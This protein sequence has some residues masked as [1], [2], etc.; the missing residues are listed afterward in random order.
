MTDPALTNSPPSLAT[1]D[2]FRL[3]VDSLVDRAVLMLDPFG[4]IVSWNRGAESIFRY[5]SQDIVGSHFSC[6]Y[7]TEA[8]T[9][10][11]PERALQA[12]LQHTRLQGEYLQKRHDGTLF[13]AELSLTELK[14]P[15]GSHVGFALV[16]TDIS[17]RKRV[18][19]SVRRERD[20]N[21]HILNC[22][23]GIF[24]M[25]DESGQFL[26][27]NRR[28]ETISEYST[29]EMEHRR[30]LDFF[31]GDEKRL[32]AERIA[33]V[34]RDGHDEVEAHFV[35]R[36]GTR[37]PYYFNGVRA[38]ID[39]RPC[40][41][42]VGL[43]LS[44]QQ[45][46]RSENR[47][48]MQ[49]L[50]ERVKELTC[51][52]QA[53]RILQDNQLTT[54]EWLG[55]LSLLLPS[56]WQYCDDAA[57]RI[58]YGDLEFRSPRFSL[59]PW[60][61]SETFTDTVGNRCSI[62]VAYLVE[63]PPA[64]EGPFLAEERSLLE[65]LAE[66]LRSA[67]NN[68][69]AGAA[70]RAGETRYR[71]VVECQ[72]EFIVRWLPDGTRT[73]VND[74]YARFFS[75][76][77]EDCVG[78]NFFP[79]IPAES[80][81]GVRKKIA[82]L[83]PATPIAWDEHQTIMPDGRI[84]WTE[85][86]DHGIFDANGT[87]VEIQ[88]V[89]RDT[90]ERKHTSQ[91]LE[92]SQR[93]V[94]AVIESSPH[95]IYVFDLETQSAQYVNR[96]LTREL[97]YSDSEAP[98]YQ[99][100]DEFVRLMPPEEVPRLEHIFAAWRTLSNGQVRED[101]YRLRHADGTYRWFMGRET[102][103]VRSADGATTQILGTLYDITSRKEAEAALSANQERLRQEM[104]FIDTLMD[105]LPGLVFLFD[106]NGKFE[107]WNKAVER[108]SGYTASEIVSLSPLDLIP[109]EDAPAV[110]ESI[111]TVFT[112]GQHALEGHIRTREGKSIPYYFQGT[113]VVTPE[114]PRLLGIGIDISEQRRLE[115]QFHQ[116]QKMEA[117]GHLAGGIAH[118][119]NN[120][121]T[122]ISGYSEILLATVP[123]SAPIR[124]AIEAIQEA[125]DRAASLTR[126]LLAFS[127]QSVLQPKVLDLNDVVT[128]TEKMLS[129]VI[130]ED[131]HL[132]TVLDLDISRIKADPGQLTQILL[133]LSVNARDA[134]PQGG[135]LT[136]ETRNVE[137]GKEYCVIH[138]Y[139][140]PGKYVVLAVS[141]T[142]CGMTPEVRQRIFDPFF[143]TKEAGKGTGLG[144]SMV[145]GIVKQSGGHIEVY[146][147]VGLGTAFK[148]YFP[149]LEE[150]AEPRTFDPHGK[151]APHGAETVLLAEDEEGVRGLA[152]LA[153][154]SHGYHVL[155]STDG[156]DAVR[157]AEQHAGLIDILVTDVVMPNMSGRQ[158]AEALRHRFPELRVLYVSGYT[159]DAVVR[160]GLLQAKAAFLQKPYSPLA[161]VQKV[162]EVLNGI[163]V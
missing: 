23:P 22:L 61:Q 65:S 158:A 132:A 20:L 49:A 91:A 163:S 109:A 135:K 15:S 92:A 137:I 27:W 34:F 40:L 12:A 24:Y 150:R 102:P 120:L 42:G 3:L 41:L 162:R 62:E 75:M 14:T 141:D 95:L 39:G 1:N 107:K 87:L 70:L 130:G 57:V 4:K 46:A 106:A 129:R 67:L 84:G 90:T 83:T 97:G 89:G 66:M 81:A 98:L 94:Q 157:V 138:P 96:S 159:D 115:A 63:K 93:Y 18:D 69:L 114:G 51:L 80:H 36:S 37:T 116:A 103:F 119:F 126:Q 146:S 117:V 99:R 47:R 11:D 122:I 48:L 5:T 143:T 148:V 155:A 7:P 104:A 160:H 10:R 6:L 136:L 112:R 31:T 142:G 74:A 58:R 111:Q 113:R 60:L 108:V 44:L 33:R 118:D 154:R 121:L 59:T 8:A 86:T 144:L 110:A 21:A 101:E 76:R 145:Y 64:A 85:W 43:D 32:V 128:D 56:G 19:E 28:F 55:R 151:V 50:G 88:S 17:E 38:E 156:K 9:T 127:R 134:M 139:A 26:C 71:H 53:A 16:I 123:E 30:P 79:L 149:A 45:L 153:L 100:L 72:S 133:N 52:H 147:E 82:S 54:A 68:R 125:G 78:T 77:P 35:S 124:D 73:F 140:R 131:V 161:L 152:M 29:A 25:Y 13:W 105:S 2:P